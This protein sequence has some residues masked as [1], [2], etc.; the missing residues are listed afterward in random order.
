MNIHI[1]HAIPKANPPTPI[2]RA[3]SG[4]GNAAHA[5]PS[6]LHSHAAVDPN[7]AKPASLMPVRVGQP[8]LV[9]SSVS[10]DCTAR[11][12]WYMPTAR[13]VR[14]RPMSAERTAVGMVQTIRLALSRCRYPTRT[15]LAAVLPHAA[16]PDRAEH[17]VHSSLIQ[18]HTGLV[19]K[20][21][22]ES[23]SPDS[24][25][26]TCLKAPVAAANSDGS[27][28]VLPYAMRRIKMKTACCALL[29]ALTRY[30]GRQTDA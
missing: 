6:G 2:Q 24:L 30:P 26:Y 5:N 4:T 16:R 13:K 27:S 20:S 18:I 21:L 11:M 22:E 7:V 15:R 3:Q 1:S 9:R 17:A 28:H 23:R 25:S 12:R 14:L 29:L 8:S 19:K 10:P